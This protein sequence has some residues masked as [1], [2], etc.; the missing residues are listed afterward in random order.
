MAAVDGLCTLANVKLLLGL[1]ID[2]TTRD[3]LLEKL[4]TVASAAASK[5]CSRSFERQTVTG[6]PYA[7]N[8]LPYLFLRVWPVQEIA[9]VVVCG[10]ALAA[11][12]D[13]SASDADKAAG[14]LYRPSGWSSPS[15]ARGIFPEPAEGDRDIIVS[16][17]GGYYLP[18]DQKYSPG[19]A[20]SL[21]EDLQGIV[22][23]A[24]CA[25]FSIIM[26]DGQGL[27]SLKEGAAAYAFVGGE[28]LSEDM[29]RALRL[30][31]RYGA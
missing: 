20:D 29:K 1:A 13:Y 23:A 3:A 19:A 14:R 26:K 21:P 10:Q 25:R 17:V 27:A 15:I 2:D 11:G 9:S 5:E 18:A 12:T 31:R 4:I 22:E 28:I 30:Y 7:A 6:E 24:V 8:G 16:Y